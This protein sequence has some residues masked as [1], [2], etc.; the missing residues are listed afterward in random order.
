[1]F[2]QLAQTTMGMASLPDASHPETPLGEF[3][4]PGTLVGRYRVRRELGRGG[5]G[6]VYDAEDPHLARS[7]AIKVLRRRVGDRGQVRLLAEARAMAGVVH[8]NVCAVYDVGAIA[9]RHYLA[10]ECI[11]SGTL[12]DWLSQQRRGVDEIV[13][14]FVSAGRGLAAGHDVGVV[15]RDFKPTNVLV[16]GNGRVV[17]CDFGLAATERGPDRGAGD[18]PVGGTPR[19]MAPEQRT[20]AGDDRV[21]QYAFAVALRD[22]LA[23]HRLPLRLKAVLRR[24]RSRRPQARFP[25]MRG[26]LAAVEREAAPRTRSTLLGAGMIAATVG[27]ALGLVP[28]ADSVAEVAAATDV[29]APQVAPAVDA[30]ISLT[31]AHAG[32]GRPEEVLALADLAVAQARALDNPAGVAFALRFRGTQLVRFGRPRQAIA[33]LTDAFYRSRQL[34][35]DDIAAVA[36]M[37]MVGVLADQLGDPRQALVWGRHA[38]GMLGRL[39][40]LDAQARSDFDDVMGR[41]HG[42]LGQPDQARER[43]QRAVA[44]LRAADPKFHVG[45]PIKLG[46][47][48]EADRQL[49]DLDA[50]QRHVLEAIDIAVTLFGPRSALVGSLTGT[51]GSIWVEQGHHERGLQTL[52]Q[53]RQIVVERLSEDH[54]SV[55][56]IDASRASALM[57]LERYDDAMALLQQTLPRAQP[58]SFRCEILE[59]IAATHAR[60]DRC[61]EA[62]PAYTV[63]IGCWDDV[64]GPNAPQ[65][66]RAHR[67]QTACP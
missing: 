43:L 64:F 49:G 62:G 28:T 33:S 45:L 25:T 10:M 37:L 66:Q 29:A 20:G 8:P 26:L 27:L 19:Y 11:R 41:A 36:A 57:K 38:E 63:A 18:N 17:V 67:G 32:F 53:G 15:H 61:D 56:G 59:R 42:A 40:H 24:A 31:T 13:R 52:V 65:A 1:M 2:A 51:L 30:M 7:V 50:A 46:S 60:Q 48:A 9:G 44:T 54:G 3:L 58:G 47:L 23:G 14:T 35:R 22:A 55:V 34:G 5:M 16:D 39:T 4:P 12:A 21:D 6:V